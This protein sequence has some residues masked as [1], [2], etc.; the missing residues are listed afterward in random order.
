MVAPEPNTWRELLAVTEG[1]PE[2]RI[3]VQEYGRPN[4]SCSMVCAAAAPT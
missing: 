4:P 2:R 3:A 1:R